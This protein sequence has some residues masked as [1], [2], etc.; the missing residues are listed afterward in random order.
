MRD[1]NDR[2]REHRRSTR[3]DIPVIPKA[4]ILVAAI[5]APGL[6]GARA[7]DSART[8]AIGQP[9]ELA[10]GQRLELEAV[11]DSRCAVGIRCAHPGHVLL[12]MTWRSQG[13]AEPM[14]VTL[15]DS[16]ADGQAKEACLN[17][18]LVQVKGVRPLPKP[19][20]TIAQADY[21]VSVALAT[22]NDEHA[23]S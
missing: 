2:G 18:V 23:R 9:L 21:M 20:A 5:L 7:A 1:T 15:S 3:V 8:F 19:S 6:P 13:D 12:L 11:A 10:G 16:A 14:R 4:F 22:C 17:G